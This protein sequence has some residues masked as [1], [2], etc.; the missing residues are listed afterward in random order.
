VVVTP[1]QLLLAIAEHET[2]EKTR[3]ALQ[4]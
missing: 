1:V 4:G 3:A 2:L